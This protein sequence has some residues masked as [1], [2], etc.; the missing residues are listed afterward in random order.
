M[1][2]SG[3]WPMTSGNF[4]VP[5]DHEL[6]ISDLVDPRLNFNEKKAIVFTNRIVQLFCMVDIYSN[7]IEKYKN[8]LFSTYKALNFY[9]KFL[10]THLLI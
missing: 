8:D 3:L 6:F 2:V 7:L 10:H 9:S 4:S 1:G 5:L